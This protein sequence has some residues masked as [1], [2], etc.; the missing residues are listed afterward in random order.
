MWACASRDGRGPAALLRSASRHG[1]GDEVPPWPPRAARE[2]KGRRAGAG[3][4]RPRPP[5]AAPAG[6]PPPGPGRAPGRPASPRCGV[7]PPEAPGLSWPVLRQGRPLAPPA[8]VP[9]APRAFPQ[10]LPQVAVNLVA[11]NHTRSSSLSPGTGLTGQTQEGRGQGGAGPSEPSGRTVS[12]RFQPFPASRVTASLVSGPSPW[13]RPAARPR[14]CLC[15][16]SASALRGPGRTLGP[17]EPRVVPSQG[18]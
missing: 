17:R 7:C 14:L 6:P 13:S 11:Q 5:H 16:P 8:G 15:D 3:G 2:P 9:R 12:G 10:L 1:T 18:P 4:G